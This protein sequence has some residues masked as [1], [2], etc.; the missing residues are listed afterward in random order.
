MNRYVICQMSNL[1]MLRGICALIGGR[2]GYDANISIFLKIEMNIFHITF[3]KLEIFEFISL[4]L[5]SGT[6]YNVTLYSK[7]NLDADEFGNLI[8]LI[9][10][11][12][13]VCFKQIL[14]EMKDGRSL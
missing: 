2:V 8:S 12:L 5:H 7:I 14:E 10:E 4:F 1:P 6:S 9:G 13:S 3:S 11:L